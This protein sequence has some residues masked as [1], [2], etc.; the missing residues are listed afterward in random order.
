MRYHGIALATDF[1]FDGVNLLVDTAL[2]SGLGFHHVVIDQGKA[3]INHHG[4]RL[5]FFAQRTIHID[6]SSNLV[7][8]LSSGTSSLEFA[9]LLFDAGNW[10]VFP[11]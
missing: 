11:A 5:F 6:D 1:V 7:R 9:H 8:S 10:V 4:T 3:S 2:E